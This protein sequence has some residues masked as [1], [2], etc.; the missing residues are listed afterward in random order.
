MNKYWLYVLFSAL[1]EVFWVAGLK[2]ADNLFEWSLTIIA[3]I[4][5]F[6]LLPISAKYLHVGTLYTV[7]AGLGTAGTVLVEIMVFG[8]PFNLLKVVLIGIL[9]IGVIGLKQ[10]SNEPSDTKGAA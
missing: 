8:E 10:V 4:I 9:L 5:T 7:F 2:H 1:F 3:I 6:I